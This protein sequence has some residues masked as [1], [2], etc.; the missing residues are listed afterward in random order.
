MR[1]EGSEVKKWNEDQE[2]VLNFVIFDRQKYTESAI[3][4]QIQPSCKT[5]T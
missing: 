5:I 2:V 3:N 4:V 1:A